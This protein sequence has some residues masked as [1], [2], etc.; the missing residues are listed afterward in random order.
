M[1]VVVKEANDTRNDFTLTY[2]K[3]RETLVDIKIEV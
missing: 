2:W 3:Y 1:P